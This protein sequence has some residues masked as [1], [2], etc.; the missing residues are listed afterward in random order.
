MARKHQPY[1]TSD[2]Q[3]IDGLARLPD[4]RWYVASKRKLYRA[5]TEAEA[6]RKFRSFCGH[7]APIEVDIPIDI[8][9]ASRLPDAPLV[10]ITD[11]GIRQTISADWLR[12][13]IRSRLTTDAAAFAAEIG[14]PSLATISLQSTSISLAKLI[15]VYDRL[16]TA[17]ARVKGCTI[18]V[19]KD[20][21][22]TTGATTLDDITA[23]AARKWRDTVNSKHTGATVNAYYSRLR[24]V[25]RYGLRDGLDATAISTALQRLEI[26]AH[27]PTTPANPTPISREDY[28]R[29]LAA[30][31]DN[32][33]WRFIL[34]MGL[35]G[36]MYMED[37]LSLEW[38]NIKGNAVIS[39]RRKTGNQIRVC[40]LW[41]ETVAAL[42][43]IQR[44]GS[45]ILTSRLG[46]RYNK[47]S[48][49]NEYRELA[50][51]AGVTADFRSLRDG[52]YTAMIQTP[53]VEEKYAKLVCGHSSGM[54]DKYVS[55][56][57]ACVAHA[58]QAIR[59][60]Y[61]T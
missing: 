14:I 15:E 30:A 58:C 18:A 10:S 57:P 20:F 50:T 56:N 53:G 33:L 35:N 5:A 38:D 25:I 37:I 40:I 31:G 23:A 51:R 60:Y 1:R 22:R 52:A 13:Y 7:A 59:D 32:R 55:A 54:Q 39:R 24:N 16:S 12:S 28:Q 26:L 36:A 11:S 45:Y 48:K 44:R 61:L 42:Q 27:V 6:I 46:T 43:Q 41:P 34:L 2:G 29:L 17:T 47:N 49:V 4:G 8:A 21:M 19:V 9:S 3:L